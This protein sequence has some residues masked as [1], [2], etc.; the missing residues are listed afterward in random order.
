[1]HPGRPD[2]IQV[3]E[4][5][6]G[7]NTARKNIACFPANACASWSFSYATHAASGSKRV[8][9]ALSVKDRK[10]P[11]SANGATRS[12]VRRGQT[13]S[14]IRRLSSAVHRREFRVRVIKNTL[15]H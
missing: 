2:G 8:S 5:S 3:Y 4:A 9:V 12:D 11:P 14:A 15:E 6:A 1:M 10:R 13:L 7:A